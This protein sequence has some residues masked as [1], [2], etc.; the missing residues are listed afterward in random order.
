LFDGRRHRSAVGQAPPD[1]SD[2]A[3]THSTIQTLV[4]TI[5]GRG[6]QPEPDLLAPQQ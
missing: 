5:G 3:K 1:R 2:T 4:L 6:C